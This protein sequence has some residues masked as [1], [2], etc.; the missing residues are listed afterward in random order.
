MRSKLA[1]R[2][3]TSGPNYI[4]TKP[5][6]QYDRTKLPR[7]ASTSGQNWPEGPVSQ[8]QTGPKGQYIRTKLAQRAST[9]GPNWPGVPVSQDQTGPKGQFIRS[10]LARRSPGVTEGQKSKLF[11]IGQRAY[12]IEA[13]CTGNLMNSFLAPPKDTQS[14]QGSPV[15]QDPTGPKGQYNGTKLAR[16]A[17]K[18]GPNWP[19]GPVHHN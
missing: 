5:K 3:S 17:S 19:E 7:R 2:A 12:Q 10:R 9:S 18:S 11:E 16:R 14:H 4:R 15:Q 8:D 1:W 6:G 13:N